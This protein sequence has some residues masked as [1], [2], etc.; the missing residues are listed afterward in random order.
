MA[1]VNNSPPP[2]FTAHNTPG[3][4]GNRDSETD[5]PAFQQY[6]EKDFPGQG[7]VPIPHVSPA[8]AHVSSS[9]HNANT[10]FILLFYGVFAVYTK[11]SKM[12]V[13]LLQ[14]RKAN[15]HKPFLSAQNFVICNT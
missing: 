4:S 7:E 15:I 3:S 2:S 12:Q 14:M 5:P 9:Y 1:G 8:T 6:L 13:E 10:S 11:L